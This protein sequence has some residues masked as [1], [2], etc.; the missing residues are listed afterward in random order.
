MRWPFSR[1]IEPTHAWGI[2]ALG[3]AFVIG[4]AQELAGLN[5]SH[6]G[7]RWWLPTN[8]M[9]LPIAILV[10]GAVSLVVP[11]RRA[12]AALP[13]ATQLPTVPAVNP[14]EFKP[15]HQES[16]EFP[17]GKA[18]TFGFDHITDHPAAYMALNPRRCTV[19]SPSGVTTEATRH[20]RYFQYP[21]EFGN[22]PTV[23]PGLYRFKLEGQ[24]PSGEWAFITRGEHEVKAPPHSLS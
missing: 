4:L 11:V 19:V 3:T 18:L 14:D 5:G 1:R 9:A 8:W 12:A 22:A 21:R 15:Y 2:V 23:S 6:A 17:D 20:N 16:G 10:I 24:L 7:F 13:A